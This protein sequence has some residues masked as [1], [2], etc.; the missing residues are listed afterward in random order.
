MN[1]ISHPTLIQLQTTPTHLHLEVLPSG[2]TFPMIFV[3][4]GTYMMGND[5]E[6]AYND[7]KPIHSVQLSDYYIGQFPVTQALWEAVM[8][9]NP[10]YFKGAHRPVES[11][12]WHKA[13][14]FCEQLSI[15]TKKKYHLPSEAQ[16]EYAAKGGPY[17]KGYTY[18]GSNHLEMVG[19]YDE[20][21]HVQTMP[22][23]LK[24]PNELG[25]YE[26]SG[27]VGEWCAD[28]Y[29]GSDYYQQ[30]KDQGTVFDPQGPETGD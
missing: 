4:G 6:E 10:S 26:C 12:S 18:S 1:R 5:T 22:V 9:D 29:G 14:A 20:N 19:W 7:E 16:W 3:P 23:G 21:G 28:W 8:N 30:C 25:L 2:L 17:S 11:I 15:L 13:M 24:C 27:N